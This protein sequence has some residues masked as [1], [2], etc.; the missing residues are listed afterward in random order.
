MRRLTL[1]CVLGLVLAA[2]AA[3]QDPA[4]SPTPEPTPAPERRIAQGVLAGHVD[5]GG[6]L[7]EEAAAKLEQELGPRLAEPVV[8]AV[9]G[10]RWTLRPK[11]VDFEWSAL[12]T[13]E[14]AYAAGQAA[15]PP[16]PAA[17]G[18]AA[19]VDVPVSTRFRRPAVRDFVR[20]IAK[21]VFIKPRNARLRF[22]VARMVRYHSRKGRK[23]ENRKVRAAIH[24]ALADPG[25]DRLLK[26][27]RR[28]TKPKIDAF[29]L[30]RLYPTVI[31]VHRNGFRL[32]LFKRLKLVK[33][34]GV[35]VGAP[36][37]ETPTG[38]FSITNR[39]VNPVW[40]AP[41]KPWAGEFAGTSIPGGSAANPLK[42]RWLGIVNGVGIHGTSA[43]YSIGTRASHGCIRMRVADVIDLYRRVPIGT[44][45]Y[46]K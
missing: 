44:P 45:V 25:L 8:V 26:P 30:E 7:V 33:S 35:A 46:I 23:L 15:P 29:D 12:V 41:N 38:T 36:G 27:G 6:L 24:A 9:A 39:A 18:A 3:A 21:R 1:L 42:A 19:S 11:R 2:P 5:V 28:E 10:R 43:E 16:D 34:Y 40:N 13:A 14:D 4:P 37:Y 31:T 20:R 32:R 22:T 17:G